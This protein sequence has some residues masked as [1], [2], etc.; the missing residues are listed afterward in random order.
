MN[1]I[2]T[3]SINQYWY[4]HNP[5]LT[6]FYKNLI[7]L[8]KTYQFFI[9]D[10]LVSL[11][12]N[13]YEYKCDNEI[14]LEKFKK[15]DAEDTLISA[16]TYLTKRQRILL[17]LKLNK[18]INEYLKLVDRNKVHKE[19]YESIIQISNRLSEE[20]YMLEPIAA[21][22]KFSDVIT[23]GVMKIIMYKT[24]KQWKNLMAEDYHGYHGLKKTLKIIKK[25]H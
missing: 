8:E 24:F 4:D 5:S 1:K 13:V 6:L 7:L 15:S 21:T 9:D 20:Q 12:Y 23:S 2:T 14:L 16:F 11:K 19:A 3:T 22:S 25:S 17:A 10:A 18:K